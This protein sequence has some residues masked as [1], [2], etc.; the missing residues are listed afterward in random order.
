MPD[1]PLIAVPGGRVEY[2]DVPGRP[3]RP[4]LLFLHE[5][6]GSVGLWRGFHRDVA[7][8]TGRRAVAYSRLG[9]G[10]SDLPAAKRSPAFMHE[11]AAV[12]VPAVCAAL[13][14]ERPAVVGHSD[15]A[16]IALLHAATADVAALV[17]MAPHV[18]VEPVGL[19][20]IAAAR[21]EFDDGGLRARMARHH[22]DPE[23]TF[24]SW[25]EVWLD[26]AF[27]DWDL[28]PEIAGIT[29][30]VLAVQGTEDPYGTV[31]HVE[32]IRDC[33]AAHDVELLLLGGGHSPHLEHR[34][35]VTAAVAEFIERPT[36]PPTPSA[37]PR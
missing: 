3:D 34:E 7:A 22:R 30:P 17:V 24:R 8:A 23:V 18:F 11:E 1:L 33:V 32:A 25:N 9:H 31:A 29:C 35:R 14:L 16:S 13:G 5:G 26:P 10:R 21:R 12:V 20:G 37:P 6:L 2:E 19:T 4:P 27:A 28:R 36:T 15:G